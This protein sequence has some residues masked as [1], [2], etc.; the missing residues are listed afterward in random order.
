MLRWLCLLTALVAACLTILAGA[1]S[2]Q[3]PDKAKRE[4]FTGAFIGTR[5][6][7]AA[8]IEYYRLASGFVAEK[9]TATGVPQGTGFVDPNPWGAYTA[10]LMQTNGKGQRTWRIENDLQMNNFTQGSTM[11][12][13][14]GAQRALLVDTAQNT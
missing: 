13:L 14:E 6:Q 10:Y 2:A 5:A 11:Y 4:L 12:L 8:P 3:I 1:A 9:K 7:T